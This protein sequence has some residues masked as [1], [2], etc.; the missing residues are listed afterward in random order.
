M[1]KIHYGKVSLV[2]MFAAACMF[3]LG[4]CG[5]SLRS[6]IT[7]N[8][9][10]ATA[11]DVMNYI[12]PVLTAAQNIAEALCQAGAV[13]NK[14]CVDIQVASAV[15]NAAA[16]AFKA[17]PTTANHQKLQSAMKPVYQAVNTAAPAISTAPAAPAAPPA[18]AAAAA[19]PTKPAPATPSGSSK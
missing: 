7:T 15:A 2:C 6:P 17:S 1:K 9:G 8:P 16:A 4:G 10:V 12:T 18:P 5:A 13:G 19:V 14:A 3:A 11:D